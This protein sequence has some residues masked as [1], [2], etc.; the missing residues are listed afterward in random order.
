MYT[1]CETGERAGLG[2]AVMESF[3]DKLK[4]R[5]TV[6]KGTTVTMEKKIKVREK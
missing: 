4:V 5:S 2:F 3:T 6:G 1:T